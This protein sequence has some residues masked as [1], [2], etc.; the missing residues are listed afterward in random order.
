MSTDCILISVSFQLAE[1]PQSFVELKQLKS[2][3]LYN[4]SLHEL[5]QCLEL[6]KNLIR[7]DIDGVCLSW[8]V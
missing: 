6:L 7:L 2:L 1:L 8:N 4:N 5:P 3:D